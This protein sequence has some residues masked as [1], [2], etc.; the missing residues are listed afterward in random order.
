M[1]ARLAA[2]V[3]ECCRI[4]RFMTTITNL[5]LVLSILFAA[6]GIAEASTQTTT[7]TISG[8]NNVVISGLTISTTSGDCIDIVNSTNVTIQASQI[9]P[10]GT[11]NSTNNSRGIYISGNSSGINIY[12]S[13][14]HVENLASSCG[15]S[16]DGIFITNTNGPVTIQGNVIAFNE[17]NIQ[18]WDASNVT[19]VGNFLLNPRGAAQCSNPDNLGGQQFQAWADTTTPNS[20]MT[21]SNNYAL[22]SSGTQYLYPG[23]QSDAINFGVTNGIIAQN[24]WISG[25]NYQ[26]AC[27][28]IADDMAN[29]AQ[30]IN[31]VISNTFNCGIGIASGTNQMVSGNKVLLI[32]PTG[33]STTGISANGGYSPV[34]CGPVS[35]SNNIA[36]AIQ[37]SGWIQSYYN[38]GY[39]TS[40]T[41]TNNTWDEAAYNIL[42]PITSTNPPPLVPPQ[43]HSCVV[44]SPY[45]T[46]TSQASCSGSGSGSASGS[47]SS[48]PT[49]TLAASPTSIS[50]GQSSVLTWSS[51]NATSCTGAGFSAS[52]GSG[53]ASI[54]PTST[55]TYSITCSN[56]GGSA[57]ASATVTVTTATSRHGNSKHWH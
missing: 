49:V 44:A 8:Q 32:P 15:T 30:F 46:Q 53:S 22:T 13:Y 10:C 40:V 43:P 24:N 18:V 3:E 54:T 6:A 21:V 29:S 25:G 38:N 23:N 1:K 4:L 9:G 45:S 37:S 20:N 14:I 34:P 12:D 56:G 35:I 51:T 31:N 19:A 50:A 17:R 16:H 41:Q 47:G 55:S 5:A 42:Y 11:A 26:N 39:C 28:L 2:F 27:G 52:G 7:L 36:Y 57:N 33:A 48:P